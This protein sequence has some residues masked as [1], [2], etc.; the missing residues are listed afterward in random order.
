[1]TCALINYTNNINK[2]KGENYVI[3]WFSNRAGCSWSCAM[4][5]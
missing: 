4:A 3:D 2:I 5:D 1:M